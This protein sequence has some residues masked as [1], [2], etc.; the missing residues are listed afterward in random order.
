MRRSQRRRFPERPRTI[1]ILA[2]GEA[3]FYFDNFAN[4]FDQVL[5]NKNMIE[6][7]SPIH[8]IAETAEI[9]RFPGMFDPASTY[10]TPIPFGGLASRS[11]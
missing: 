10:R 2:T 6:D 7:G 4:F 5:V 11:T 1:P 9:I 8:V 3:S